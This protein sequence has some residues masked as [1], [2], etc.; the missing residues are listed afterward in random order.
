MFS[1]KC[2]FIVN[3]VPGKDLIRFE[4]F[5]RAPL[6]EQIPEKSKTKVNCQIISTFSIRTE[7]LKKE[8]LNG[9]T[10]QRVASYT[11]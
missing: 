1:Q 4:T 8:T 10:L 6:K 9:N 5:S 7:R 11:T 2:D 3:Q